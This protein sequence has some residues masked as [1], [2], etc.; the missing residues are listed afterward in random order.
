MK[1]FKNDANHVSIYSE[2]FIVPA[3]EVSFDKS[4]LKEARKSFLQ[5]MFALGQL[6]RKKRKEMQ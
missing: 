6:K 2:R 1:T 4:R 3:L 5:L